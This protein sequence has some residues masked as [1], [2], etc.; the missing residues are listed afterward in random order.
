MT[1][2]R[3]GRSVL[4]LTL[5][6][7]VAVVSGISSQV[8]QASEWRGLAALS[9]P[10]S[11]PDAAPWSDRRGLR[12]SR[13]VYRLR[14]GPETGRLPIV[15]ARSGLS[16]RPLASVAPGALIVQFGN[17]VPG[18]LVADGTRRARALWTKSD[19]NPNVKDK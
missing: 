13:S 19:P 10:G 11:P 5:V 6:F 2:C 16:S 15:S 14:A 17:L 4:V 1:L 8:R 7:G 18:R 3:R 9:R 12:P